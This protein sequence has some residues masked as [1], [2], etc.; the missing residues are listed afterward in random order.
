[1]T[2]IQIIISLQL[3]KWIIQNICKSSSLLFEVRAYIKVIQ[4]ST[5][6]MA[7]SPAANLVKSSGMMTM[8]LSNIVFL[9]LGAR[10]RYADAKGTITHLFT[11]LSL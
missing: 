11:L 8:R 5:I 1:M 7:V 10:R 2:Q 4:G 3:L 9:Q 6:N